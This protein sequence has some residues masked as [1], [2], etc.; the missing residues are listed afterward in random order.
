[1]ILELKVS[2]LDCNSLRMPVCNYQYVCVV[3]FQA[4]WQAIET[5]FEAIVKVSHTTD[6]K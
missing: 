5:M 4:A 3:L 2:W 6:R 1:M